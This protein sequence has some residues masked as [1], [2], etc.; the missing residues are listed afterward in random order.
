MTVNGTSTATGIDAINASEKPMKLMIDGQIYILRGEKM[1][2][3][4]G[5]LVK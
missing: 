5:K 4:T 3:V 2:D 1:Y